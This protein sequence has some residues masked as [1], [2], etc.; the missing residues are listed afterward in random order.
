MHCNFILDTLPLKLR[1][2]DGLGQSPLASPRYWLRLREEDTRD[3]TDL[4]WTKNFIEL[5]QASE[6]ARID[7]QRSADHTK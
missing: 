7:V 6:L 3:A 1:L 2:V 5:K 4:E